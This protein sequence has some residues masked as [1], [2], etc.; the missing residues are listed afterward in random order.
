[1][2]PGEHYR[3]QREALTLLVSSLTEDQLATQV[4]GCPLWQVRDVVAHLVGLVVD[5]R[6]GVLPGGA[7]GEAWTQAQVDDRRGRSLAELV[8]EWNREAPAFEDSLADLG[9]RGWIFVYDV[10]MHGDDL[11]ETLGLALGTSETHAVVLDGLIDLARSRAE[12]LGTLTLDAG[13]QQWSLGD[14][15][16][17][18][19]L[20]VRDAGELGRIV[21]ARR[22]DEAVR[23]MD[24]NGDPEPWLVALPL[25][26]GGR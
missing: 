13:A 25:F 15:E 4:P 5:V 8:E 14:G 12:G 10:T 1:M 18:A 3:A 7:G 21:G 2:G 16:P 6:A 9:F 17:K 22:S 11:R 19:S 23:A 20:T 24:W 26:R